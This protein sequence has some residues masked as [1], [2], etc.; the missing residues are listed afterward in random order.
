MKLGDTAREAAST[1]DLDA[2]DEAAESPGSA[3][4]G[5]RSASVA[6][7]AQGIAMTYGMGRVVVLGEAA[8]LSAQVARFPD[9][10]EIK[11]GMNV[12]GNDNRRFALNVVHWLS[13]LGD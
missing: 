5:S 8:I 13:R 7:R 12:P 2:E 9:G 3:Q 11:M 10:R 6:A 1:D 4:L